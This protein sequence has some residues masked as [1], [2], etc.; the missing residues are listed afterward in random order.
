ME[1]RPERTADEAAVA[2]IHETAFP[3]QPAQVVALVNDLR[4]STDERDLVSLVAVDD[5][6]PIGHALFT[7]S[8]L[9]ALDRPVQ[10]HV[11]SPIGVL[12]HVQR[13]GVGSALV[14]EGIRT[15]DERGVPAVFLEG[16]P[17][18]YRR[19]G[20][21]EAGPLGFR[22]PSLRIP[23]LAFQV[24]TLR[25]Y[26]PWMTGTFVYSEPFWRNDVVGLRGARLEHALRG[27]RG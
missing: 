15:L 13:R 23:D 20:F 7:P 11:L 25:A 12:P 3:H 19:F 8:L 1:I 27:G 22:K 9:D 10:V 5:D 16:D 4:S 2:R 17:G 26:E 24:R 18:Y 14:G 21:V 6:E